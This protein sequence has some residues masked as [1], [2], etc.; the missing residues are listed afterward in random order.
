MECF[1]CGER[2]FGINA[3]DR[4][5]NDFFVCMTCIRNTIWKADDNEDTI[6]LLKEEIKSM[7]KE[8]ELLNQNAK[9]MQKEIELLE[10]EIK[11]INSQLEKY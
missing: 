3:L 4:Q 7:Q 2:G 1:Y 6:K 9:S 8:I 11:K 5:N 10:K